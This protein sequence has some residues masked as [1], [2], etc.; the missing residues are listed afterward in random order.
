M[1][2]KFNKINNII[3]IIKI[4][5][6]LSQICLTTYISY[7]KTTLHIFKNHFKYNFK[8]LT[9]IS[10]TD[11]LKNL[12]RFSIFYEILSIKYNNRLRL[13]I[14]TNELLPIYTIKSIYISAIW[15]ED[16]IWDLFG[17]TFLKRKNLIRLL[18]D[19]GFIGFPLRKDF[20][21]SGF[22][23]CKYSLITNKIC[24]NNLETAQKIRN[25][26]FASPWL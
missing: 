9:A 7:F 20:P 3:P 25:F 17:V 11:Y 12:N 2:I 8:I 1:L 18:T 22:N 5:Y 6:N 19:Y 23:D 21:L 14:L 4:Q 15:W 10:C 24:Y 16:E 13:K 26:Y